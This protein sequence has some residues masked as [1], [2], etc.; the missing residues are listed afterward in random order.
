MSKE[1]N[2]L[3]KFVL[4]TAVGVGIGMLFA[5]EKGEKT[6]KVLAQKIEE[7]FSKLKEV[8]VEEVKE[9]IERRVEEIKEA[10]DDLDKEK[11]MKIAKAKAKI[12]AEK[13]E[14]L[15]C[16]AKRKG[17]PVLESATEAVREEAIKVTKAVLEKL[18][19]GE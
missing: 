5:P 15:V 11:V 12:I 9:T 18:E 19:S 16:Y 10:L 1:K 4:G 6:R 8:D 3:G 2:G 13:A 14:D 7:L 17:T